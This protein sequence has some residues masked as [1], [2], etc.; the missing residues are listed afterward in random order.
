VKHINL[1]GKLRF[2]S[3][4]SSEDL[5]NRPKKKMSWIKYYC[6]AR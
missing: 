3:N 2:E 5:Y 6:Y 1:T 4:M